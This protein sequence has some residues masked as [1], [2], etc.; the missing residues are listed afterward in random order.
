MWSVVVKPWI[1][2]QP[3]MQ[4]DKTEGIN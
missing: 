3:V 2:V 1:L 4:P